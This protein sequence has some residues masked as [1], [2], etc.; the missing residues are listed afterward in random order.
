M[1]Q[2]NKPYSESCEQ[3]RRP[4]LSALEKL[5]PRTGK[6]LEIGAGTG[7][8]AVYFAPCFAGLDW[9]PTD[10]EENIPG[11]V[12]W[13]DEARISNI[14]PPRVLDMRAPDWPA[15]KFD[16]VFSANTVHIMA[17]ELVEVMFEGIGRLLDRHGVFCL[18]GPFNYHGR[19][20]S[21]SNARFDQ[22]L[23]QRDP[24]SGIRDIDQL[25]SLA[26]D[27]GMV[28]DE[29]IEMPVNNRMLV[30]RHA[31]RDTGNAQRRK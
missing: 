6:L 31:V 12:M 26:A 11:I 29:D 28:L 3:N 23:R 13:L 24:Q 15:L 18:Y 21:P 1:P 14:R 20:T 22:W 16:A 17:W 25:N 10:V 4:I 5:L 2:G 8:H 30:F 7:Q 27:S 9:Y 19:Y